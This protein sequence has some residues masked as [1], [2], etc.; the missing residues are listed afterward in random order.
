[1]RNQALAV[2]ALVVVLLGLLAT[3][4]LFAFEDGIRKIDW[5]NMEAAAL[6]SG[7][8]CLVG[9]VLGW[10]SFKA[11]A[12]KAAAILGSLLVIFFVYQFMRTEAPSQSGG[13]ALPD[14]P[15]QSGTGNP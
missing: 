3:I 8:I 6:G 13:P 14:L 9:C 5:I 2:V 11:G 4:S 15:A 1:M 10:A 12:G 7:L